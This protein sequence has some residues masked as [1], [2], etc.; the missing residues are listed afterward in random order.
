M[1]GSSQVWRLLAL[2]TLTA[3]LSSC[4]NGAAPSQQISFFESEA[5]PRE[6]LPRA[7]PEAVGVDPQA[8]AALVAEA[9][10]THSTALIV[11]KD[12]DV[13]AERYFGSVPKELHPRPWPPRLLIT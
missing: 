9:Q 4:R 2:L 6:F 11:I 3:F 7:K 12:G 5:A 13:I 1:T 8:L 10:N